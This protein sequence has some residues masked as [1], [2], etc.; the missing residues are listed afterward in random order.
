MFPHQVFVLHSA[1]PDGTWRGLEKCAGAPG[2]TAWT[3]LMFNDRVEAEGFLNAQP[4]MKPYFRVV[5]LTL[6][7]PDVRQPL[8][9][10][11][12]LLVDDLLPA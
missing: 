6:V 8:D 4:E 10:A 12:Y 7:T 5:E 3:T 11:T 2:V 1:Y 9:S